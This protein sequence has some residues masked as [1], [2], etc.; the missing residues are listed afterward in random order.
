MVVCQCNLVLKKMDMQTY[1]EIVF[2][3][4]KPIANK[5][6][7]KLCSRSSSRWCT[8]NRKHPFPLIKSAERMKQMQKIITYALPI[9]FY[10]FSSKAG[11]ENTWN[12]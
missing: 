9:Y 6:I 8:H 7:D 3:V 1:L 2:A 12:H 11:M 5:T 10:P 4:P